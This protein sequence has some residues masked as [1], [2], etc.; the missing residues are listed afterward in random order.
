MS[1]HSRIIFFST[2]I[3]VFVIT[4]QTLLYH[5]F[6]IPI[7]IDRSTVFLETLTTQK[8]CDQAPNQAVI[9]EAKS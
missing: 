9:I 4:I 3:K 6:V 1:N 8:K 2:F 7:Q 5:G